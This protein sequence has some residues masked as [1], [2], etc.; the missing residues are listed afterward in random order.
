MIQ[1]LS[2]LRFT[3]LE[4]PLKNPAVQERILSFKSWQ[5]DFITLPEAN[6]TFL[7]YVTNFRPPLM[8]IS[9]KG[10]PQRLWRK[11][12]HCFLAIT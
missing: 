11:P 4:K 2:Y 1:N 3:L 8:N 7:Y 9:V 12:I 10:I 5:T 6:A